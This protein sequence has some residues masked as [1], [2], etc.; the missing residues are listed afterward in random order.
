MN[1]FCAVLAL[2]ACSAI[3]TATEL[4]YAVDG[5]EDPLEA[6]VLAY[7]DTLSFGRPKTLTEDDYAETI[8]EAE[9]RARAALRPFGYYNPIAK[10]RIQ[11]GQGDSLL[12][13]L[14]VR[15]GQPMII[16]SVRVEIVGEGANKE[17]LRE[18]R[19]NWPLPEGGILNQVTWEEQKRLALE[20]ARKRGF[21]AANFSRHSLQLDLER[22]RAALDLELDTGPQ[23][24]FGEVDFGEHNLKPGILE[25]IPRFR[26]GQAYSAR[27]LDEFRKDL[28]KTGYFT[29]VDVVEIERPE[30][31]PPTVDLR[32]DLESQH[33]NTYQGSFGIGSDTGMRVQA[34]WTRNPV[35]RNGD[36]LD[37]GFGW[38]EADDEFAI[39]GNYRLPRR[40]KQR[41][42]WTLEVF[43]RFENTDLEIKRNPEDEDFINVANGDINEINLRAGRLKVRNRKSGTQQLFTTPFVQYLN[44]SREFNPLIP[45]PPSGA[46][47]EHLLVGTDKAYSVGIDTQLVA[48]DGRS[49]GTQGHHERLWLFAGDN[50]IS[51][52]HEF[53][54]F[55][56]NTRRVYPMGE[57][58]KL[59]LRGEL[60][61]SLAE[62]D[63]ITL[64]L[65]DGPV[66]LS[67]T[68][69]PNFY[70]FKAG[71]SMSVRGYGFEELSD[72]DIGSN[73]IIT[74][75]A[76]IE[77][78]FLER[79]SAA[80]F[81]DIGN[82]FND[83]D[84]PELRKGIGV[85]IRW[86]SI[87]GP[88]RIDV[89]QALDITGKPWRF[90]FTIGTPLL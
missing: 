60:G 35:S 3:A 64:D 33:K 78:K 57:R 21:L 9:S 59:L 30:S 58:W 42:Y 87:A 68:R 73:N 55:Y 43:Q 83:W 34:L 23:F 49:W 62:V 1:R 6:N 16:D 38:Q 7:V 74:A 51:D 39:H 76:E 5:V 70:R 37:L 72:N 41:E 66:E 75:S 77:L 81:F 2:C 80:A 86:Y 69:L 13:T 82:A 88:I 67:V 45:I 20:I 40:S 29:N 54:Q 85:G 24:V 15:A 44:S 14:D 65:P 52:D 4:R 25:W 12:L 90:H 71:G 18:W 47:S 48:V 56:F 79:W 50:A 31:V 26:P 53:A 19:R 17:D 84:K 46:G 89:A 32:I 28:W 10:G 36:R 22:N 27:L 11:K 63:T 61:Y 8:A